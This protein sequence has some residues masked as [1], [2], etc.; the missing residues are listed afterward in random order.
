[1]PSASGKIELWRRIALLTGILLGVALYF[2]VTPAIVSVTAVDWEE[3]QAGEL[4]TITGYVSESD[5]RLS[6][7]PLDDYIKEKTGGQVTVVDS[8]QWESFFQ[9]V[10]LASYGQYDRSSYGNR[11]SEQDKDDFWKPLG[12][13]QV[14]FKP[15]ELP[16]EQWG[17]TFQAGDHAYIS[18]TVGGANYYLLLE[19]ED[20]LSSVTMTCLPRHEQS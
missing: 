1:M 6:Q 18:S 10:Q 19:Y 2:Y 17:L 8:R 11:V 12:P 9:Q 4:R 3:E 5:K 20:Y 14:F 16:F 7:L 13:V 15:G